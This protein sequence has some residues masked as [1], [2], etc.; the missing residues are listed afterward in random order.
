MSNDT[1]SLHP[2]HTVFAAPAGAG[3][4]NRLAA[5]DSSAIRPFHIGTP[6]EALIEL[7]KRINATKFP[8]K[9]T[10]TDASQGVQLATIQNCALLGD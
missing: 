10:V 6:Q 7:R 1:I 4:A 5:S 2:E 9:E 3:P 8:E